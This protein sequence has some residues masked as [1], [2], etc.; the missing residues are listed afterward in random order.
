MQ[1]LIIQYVVIAALVVGVLYLVYLLKEKGTV[2][3]E[4]YYGVAQSILSVLSSSEAT[5]DNIKKILRVIS[6]VVSYIEINFKGA[7]NDEKEEKALVMAH[8][9][10]EA[11]GFKDKLDDDSI[12]QLIRLA[13]GFNN[14]NKLI[15]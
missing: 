1:E 2:I 11:L 15:T 6:D 10:I 5:S 12:R 4:D 9:A 14:F 8:D 13:C 7:T 3:K